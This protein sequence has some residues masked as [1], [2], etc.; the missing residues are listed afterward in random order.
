MPQAAP[1]GVQFGLDRFDSSPEAAGP[2]PGQLLAKRNSYLRTSN[3]FS[4]ASAPPLPG[5]IMTGAGAGVWDAAAAAGALAT[6][7]SAAAEGGVLLLGAGR[8]SAALRTQ[9]LRRRYSSRTSHA[10]DCSSISQLGGEAAGA[11]P[12][13]PRSFSSSSGVDQGLPPTGEP[14][15][16]RS[17]R[18]KLTLSPSKVAMHAGQQHQQQLERQQLLREQ[19]EREQ[20]L[21]M[22]ALEALREQQQQAATVNVG[23]KSTWDEEVLR[24]YEAADAAGKEAILYKQLVLQQA[25]KQAGE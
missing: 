15:P 22:A 5:M 6:A 14:S 12:R 3:S 7:G 13:V 8:G 16:L 18:T 17:S 4:S 25:E 9:Q 2:L 19:Q 24:E 20:Q 23:D 10:S 21:L 11:A 1:P